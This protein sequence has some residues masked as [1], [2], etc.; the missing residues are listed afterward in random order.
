[1]KRILAAA[2]LAA[3]CWSMASAQTQAIAHRGYWDCEGSAQNSIAALVKA[4]EAGVYGSEFDVSVT[5]DGIPVV[6]HDDDIQGYLIETTPYATIK[7]LKLPNGETLPTLEA[8]LQ[9]GKTLP[10]VQLI[11]EIK[12]HRKE[13]NEDR[14]V[15]AI[16]ALVEKYGLEKRV[17]YISFSMN[18][19]KELMEAAPGAPVYYLNGDVAPAELKRLGLT[20][21]DYDYEVLRK[22]PQWIK[23]AHTLGLKTNSWTVNDKQTMQWLI[24]QG[25]DFITTDKPVELK[26][27]LEHTKETVQ[28]ASAH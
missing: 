8:Y 7:A 1:M 17:D 21:M 22:H 14:A 16:V 4:S 9:K 5:A 28:A 3:G 24:E 20:G 10:D 18:I 27:L 2:L 12:P 11:L 13:A 25:E 6:N 19:C 26:T 23:E 15:K